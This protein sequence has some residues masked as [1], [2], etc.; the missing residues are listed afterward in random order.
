[1]NVTTV[2][3]KHGYVSLLAVTGQHLAMRTTCKT[4][5]CRHCKKKVAALTAMRAVYGCLIGGPSYF[6]TVTYR[7]G[8]GSS[9]KNARSAGRDWSRLWE[10]LKKQ[11]RWKEAAWYKVPELTKKGQVHLHALVTSMGAETARCWSPSKREYK[12]FYQL[13]CLNSTICLQHELAGLWHGITGDSYVVD[14]SPI[15]SVAGASW[16][17]QKYMG[18]SFGDRAALEGLGFAR[19]WSSSRNWPRG[20]ELQLRGTRDQMWQETWA[21]RANVMT[22]SRLEKLKKRD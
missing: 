10:L 19:R 18:K 15:R 5:G 3:E 14:I 7:T 8:S 22:N 16:Y 2:C 20:V 12:K 9:L 1:M 4:W 21:E 6:I 11:S 13:G 17:V